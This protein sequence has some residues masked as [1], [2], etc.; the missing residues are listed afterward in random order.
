[1]RKFM[2]G[3]YAVLALFL[4]TVLVFIQIGCTNETRTMSADTEDLI[5]KK[6]IDSSRVALQNFWKELK[7][8]KATKKDDPSQKF[9]PEFFQY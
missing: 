4:A 5:F 8:G 6:K 2:A 9:A 3:Y 1:M 7:E